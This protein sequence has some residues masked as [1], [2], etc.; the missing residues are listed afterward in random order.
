MVVN[1]FRSRQ[2]KNLLFGEI[3]HHIVGAT[4]GTATVFVLKKTGKD[5]T[6]FKSTCI[7]FAAWAFLYN[8]GHKLDLFGNK[9]RSTSS[10]YL[11]LVQHILF[12]LTI[13][14]TIKSLANPTI[15]HQPSISKTNKVVLSD[16]PSIYSYAAESR[17]NVPTQVLQ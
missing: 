14:A 4:I 10:H 17:T 9:S 8:L 16:T 5:F 12:G 13:A 2:L 11:A 3:L 1:K 6:I 15:F 7:G